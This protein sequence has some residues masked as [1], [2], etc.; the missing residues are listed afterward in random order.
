MQSM[1]LQTKLNCK[2]R[3]IPPSSDIVFHAILLFLFLLNIVKEPV[4]METRAVASVPRRSWLPSNWWVEPWWQWTVVPHSLCEKKKNKVLNLR[5][6][7]SHCVHLYPNFFCQKLLSNQTTPQSSLNQRTDGKI[8]TRYFFRGC[9]C[10]FV[11]VNS[12]TF[13]LINIWCFW[14]ISLIMDV[15]AAH[16]REPTETSVFKLAQSLYALIMQLPFF[17]T[18]L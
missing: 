15:S 5:W 4:I 8:T 3:C 11:R 17:E 18:G 13:V 7:K 10:H 6:Q 12:D 2:H 14:I 16:F 9:E 1:R